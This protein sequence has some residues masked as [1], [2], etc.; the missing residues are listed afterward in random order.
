ME[1]VTNEPAKAAEVVAQG[2]LGEWSFLHRCS[3]GAFVVAVIHFREEPEY[4]CYRP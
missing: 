1:A 2:G 3:V 4:R